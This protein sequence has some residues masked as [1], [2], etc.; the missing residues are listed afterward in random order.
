[1]KNNRILSK[2]IIEK[3][4][5]ILN[6]IAVPVGILIVWQVLSSLGILL[7]VILPSPLKV[8]QAFVSMVKQGTLQIDYTGRG[9]YHDHWSERLR[10]N[11]AAQTDC[12]A[13]K[14]LRG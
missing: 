12:R 13:G 8:I 11:N 14:G 9:I 4:A 7:E 10:K 2:K 1:M 6:V 3:L 5:H